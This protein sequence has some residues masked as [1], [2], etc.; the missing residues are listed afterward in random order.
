MKPRAGRR[1]TRGDRA[2]GPEAPTKF[3]APVAAGAARALAT[4]EAAAW[5]ARI[6][7][8]V[9]PPPPE[10]LSSQEGVEKTENVAVSTVE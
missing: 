3:A 4:P 5:A 7:E 8:Q 9:R 1:E 2:E 10:Q 6:P